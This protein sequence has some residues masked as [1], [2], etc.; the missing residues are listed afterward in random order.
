MNPDENNEALLSHLREEIASLRAS[1]EQN[2]IG[3][4]LIRQREESSALMEVS[5]LIISE[6]NLETV[7]QLVASKAR[8]LVQ[9]DTLLVPMLDDKRDRYSYKAAVGVAAEAVRDVSFPITTG[10]CGWVLKN[11]RSLFFG[12]SSP[13]VLDETTTWEK[14]QQSAILV[15]L[16]GRKQIIGGLSALGKKGGGSFTT[17]DLDLLTLFA[18]Q[19]SIAIE[20]AILFQQVHKE[21]EERKQVEDALRASETRFRHITEAVTDYIY[22]VRVEDGKAAETR[23]GAG[24]YAVT[25][26]H[27]DDFV[28]DPFLWFRMVVDEDHGA[29]IDQAR[30]V[31]AG[32]EVPAV[33]H[34]IVRKDGLQRWVRNT[35]VP[36]HDVEGRLLAYDG[37]IQDI[38]ERKQAEEALKKNEERYRIVA[39][40][41]Y[42]WEF[43][44]C[45]EKRFIYS[46]P[47]CARIT[48][49][50]ANEFDSDPD[51]LNRLIHPDDSLVFEKHL[52]DTTTKQISGELEFRITRRDGSVRWISHVCRPVFDSTGNYLGTRGSNRD[53]T[54]RKLAEQEREQ[55]IAELQKTIAEVKTLRGILPICSYC[56]KI[57]DDAG[58]WKQM[59]SYISDHSDAEFSHGIC[60]GCKQ[61]V[62]AETEEE[63]KK[64]KA[65]NTGK[66]Q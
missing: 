52:Q 53:S 66:E 33:E 40:F 60:P 30:R 15:P 62:M 6:L 10:M 58:S 56:K 27:E 50:S 24:C 31:L 49:Y 14:G 18:N 3:R 22:T 21:V 20:N 4:Q 2:D 12:E 37:L 39:D 13:Y 8:D 57:L 29:V 44:L 5:K 46:S 48:C 42:D 16:F 32:Q 19:I 47:S 54:G 41:N 7:L 34:R 59:E 26:Y 36:R 23:H 11:E 43:W 9:A 63:I 61:R 1:L 17:H 38:T 55:L 45:H 51:L 35:I 25:G 65:R 64:I 28:R